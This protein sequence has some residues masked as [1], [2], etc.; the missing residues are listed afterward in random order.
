MVLQREQH[1]KDPVL[2][3]PMAVAPGK[4]QQHNR[5]A[6][7]RERSPGGEGQPHRQQGCSSVWQL[8]SWFLHPSCVQGCSLG[9][10]GGE[11]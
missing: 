9:S 7:E 11:R 2:L 8:G 10:R 6:A 4:Q 1:L 5:K 3:L